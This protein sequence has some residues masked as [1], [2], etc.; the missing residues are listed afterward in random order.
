MLLFICEK[1]RL[2]KKRF[3]PR[4]VSKRTSSEISPKSVGQ[5]RVM[6]KTTRRGIRRLTRSCIYYYVL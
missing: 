3:E 2:K 6:A 5:I 1:G 4:K